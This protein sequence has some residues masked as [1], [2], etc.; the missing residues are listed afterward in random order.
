MPLRTLAALCLVL[1]LAP[2]AA[3]G[4]AG[5]HA[6]Q[7]NS[8]RLIFDKTDVADVLQAIARAYHTSIVFPADSK[9]AVSLNITATSIEEALRN[10]TAAAG[11]AFRRA[12]KTYVVALPASLK[13]SLEPFG[14]RERLDVAGIATQEAVS[15]LEGAL[16]YLTVRPAGAQVLVIG[17]REDVDQARELLDEAKKGKIAEPPVSEIV[18]LRY[19]NPQQVASVVKALFTGV[20]VE[21]V[22][23]ADKPG[24][25]VGLSGPAAQVRSAV[26]VASRVDVAPADPASS[27]ATRVYMV[28]YSSA[29]QIKSFLEKAMPDLLAVVGPETY[30]PVAPSFN[31]LSGATLGGST[32]GSGLGGSGTGTGTGGLGSGTSGAGGSSGFGSRAG[33]ETRTAKEGDR[34]KTLVISGTESQVESALKLIEQVDIRPKQVSIDVRVVD[35]SPDVAEELGVKWSWNTFSLFERPSGT[36]LDTTTG[37]PSSNATRN[38]DFGRL[39]RAPLNIN[40][41]LSAMVTRKEAKLLA[42]P[43]VTV[44]DNDDANIFIG[45][46][47]RSQIVAAG[48]I[49][50]TTIQIYEFPIGIVLLVR[51]RVNADGLITMRVH[52]VVSTITSIDSTTGLPQSSSREAETTAIVKDGETIVIGGLIRDETTKTV[53][54]VPL[55]S[56]LP[57]VG[58]LFRSRKTDRRKS[59]VLVFITPRIVP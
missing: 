31:P 40:A 44:V 29:P 19:A 33:G 53:Q 20:K 15:L 14:E 1:A 2:T 16:P 54:E 18:S 57:L 58:E 52:P 42:S 55:L 10:V 59:D 56:K 8:V 9:R 35:T 34:A 27:R 39:S 46:T 48:G 7:P 32:G 13:Q 12:G 22:G 28:K 38:L 47:L 6:P 43:R 3:V 50:G 23:T 11:L 30:S 21:A 41:V 49:S 17:A 36:D 5:A 45:D 26:E 4:Q 37:Q 51:P 25:S 24:G